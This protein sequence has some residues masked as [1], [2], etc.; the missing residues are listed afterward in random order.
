MVWWW[1]GGGRIS[2][3]IDEMTSAINNLLLPQLIRISN[4]CQ[5]EPSPFKTQNRPLLHISIRV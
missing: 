2:R 4:R 3:A 5:D 1:F